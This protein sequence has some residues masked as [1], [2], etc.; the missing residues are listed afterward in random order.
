MSLAGVV[1]FV[2]FFAAAAIGVPIGQAMIATGFLYLLLSGG[3]MG[4][5]A[6]QGLNGLF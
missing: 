2:A 6:T 4:L 1:M 3:D 5:V